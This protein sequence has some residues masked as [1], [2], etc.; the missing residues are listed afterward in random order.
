MHFNIKDLLILI[1]LCFLHYIYSYIFIFVIITLHP[2]P[3]IFGFTEYLVPYIFGFTDYFWDLFS[4]NYKKAQD[5]SLKREALL[6]TRLLNKKNHKFN[7]KLILNMIL[8]FKP[9]KNIN[10][11][12]NSELEKSRIRNQRQR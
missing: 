4:A 6:I 5:L 7:K 10:N 12:M 11:M 3:H 9:N 2:N 8:T 1:K